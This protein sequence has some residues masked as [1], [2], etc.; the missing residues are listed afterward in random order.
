MQNKSFQNEW[1]IIFNPTSGGGK[2]QSKINKIISLLNQYNLV[3]EMV[4]TQYAHQEEIL[5]H[6]AIYNGFK[7]FICIGGDG[8]IHHTING[9]MKQEYE[10]SNKIKLAVIPT[11]TGNDWIKNYAIPK[12]IH[13]AIKLIVNN[14][15]VYQDIGR[16][17]LLD[18]NKEVYFNNAAGIGF[19]A[20]VVKNIFSYKKWRSLSYLMA[21]LV[22]LKKYIPVD[23]TYSIDQHKKK[24]SIFLISLGI[25]RYSGSGMQLTDYKNHKNGYLDLTLVQSI[26]L[27]R[28]ITNIISLYNGNI[29]AIKETYCS[30]IKE[31]QLH[32]NNTAYI[33]ADGELVGKGTAIFSLSPRAIQF[34]V[35]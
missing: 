32:S 18:E 17:S 28:V 12:D 22:S 9:I 13:K 3:F 10:N 30:N 27:F 8:T 15:C 7:N 25:G 11:G 20:F 29:E 4:T 1:Y 6:K 5:V 34:V 16:I 14:K 19:D 23:L 24:S 2:G 35:S 31:F 33:Q 21:A 26:S